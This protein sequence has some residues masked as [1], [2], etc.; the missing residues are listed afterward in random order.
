MQEE[1][2]TS[3][4]APLY[5]KASRPTSKGPLCSQSVIS[6]SRRALNSAPVAALSPTEAI[7]S[8]LIPHST[9]TGGGEGQSDS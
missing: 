4:G 5:E 2:Y 3:S 6:S 8:T 9:I 1:K 7:K